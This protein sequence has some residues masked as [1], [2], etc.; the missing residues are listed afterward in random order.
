MFFNLSDPAE[1]SWQRVVLR[2]IVT[3]TLVVFGWVLFRSAT[4]TEALA[5]M[6]AMLTFGNLTLPLAIFDKLSPDDLFF[7]IVGLVLCLLP[8]HFCPI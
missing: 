5:M 3:I 4:L 7:L 8:A 1:M 2:S 6:Q